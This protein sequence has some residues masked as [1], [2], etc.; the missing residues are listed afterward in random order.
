MKMNLRLVIALTSGCAALAAGWPAGAADIRYTSVPNECKMRMDGT[1]TIHDWYAESGVIGGSIQAD[2]SFPDATKGTVKPKVDVNIPV[3]TLKCS[4]G[5]KMDAIMLEHLNATEHKMIKYSVIELVPKGANAGG[6]V[7]FEAKGTL[8]VSG[9]TRT[10]TM[11]VTVAKVGGNRIKVSGATALKMT[12][13][14]VKPPAPDVGLGLIKTGDEVKLK[15]EWIT[16]KS[17]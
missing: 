8:T 14:G 17:E 7:D 5:R 16:E 12:D 6:G 3:R 4:S 9:V 10:N 15:F 11:P 2:A 13:F 1:S